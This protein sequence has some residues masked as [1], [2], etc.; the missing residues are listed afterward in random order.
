MKL[1]R[2]DSNAR[3]VH[4]QP[5]AIAS[6]TARIEFKHIDR[7]CTRRL[8]RMYKQ[9]FHARTRSM[10]N[11]SCSSGHALVVIPMDLFFELQ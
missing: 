10:V 1:A 11:H 2:S 4:E 9:G 8:E 6:G 7:N 5:A 3:T